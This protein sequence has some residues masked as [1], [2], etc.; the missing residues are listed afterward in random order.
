MSARGIAPLTQDQAEEQLPVT[1]H[2]RDAVARLA[3]AYSELRSMNN[4]PGTSDEDWYR[5]EQELGVG[6][7]S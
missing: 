4:V 5:A 6:D 3:Y 2:D 1:K 7:P